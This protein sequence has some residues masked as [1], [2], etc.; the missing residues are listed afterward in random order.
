MDEHSL[1]VIAI[2]NILREPV[3][4]LIE[5]V[6]SGGASGL[7]VPSFASDSVEAEFIGDLWGR[8]STGKIL[9]VGVNEDHSVLE[10]IIGDHF[11]EFF[12]GIVD[13]VAIV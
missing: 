3:K 2:R 8:H 11:V 10:L 13:S 9:L 12:L 7:D 1:L 4:T 5:A 6:T